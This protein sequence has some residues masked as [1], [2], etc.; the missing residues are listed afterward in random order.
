MEDGAASEAL[1]DMLS[2][3]SA[4][5]RYGAFRGLT[6]MAP[7]DRRIRGE[8]LG[9]GGKFNYHVLDVGGPPMIHVTSSHRQEVVLFGKEHH[10]ELPAVLDAGPRILV[11]GLNGRRSRSAASA[12]ASRRSSASCRPTSTK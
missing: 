1:A 9:P 10:F 12:P 8:K 5:T 2:V 3:K 7:D 6:S 11:N 4:E